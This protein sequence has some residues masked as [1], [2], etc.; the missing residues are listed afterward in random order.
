MAH[1]VQTMA[2]VGA[3]PWHGLG[4]RLPAQQPIDVWQKSAGKDW[5]IQET[6]VRFLADSIGTMGSI[7]SFEDQKV[8]YR[9]DNCSAP[10]FGSALNSKYFC[11]QPS[12]VN[13][14]FVADRF[15]TLAREGDSP[16]STDRLARS[17]NALAS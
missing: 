17:S 4:N 12:K 8:L 7:H 1:P 14:S 13:A 10:L 2:Y 6:P 15:S 5:T 3:E 16:C 9:S 11:A